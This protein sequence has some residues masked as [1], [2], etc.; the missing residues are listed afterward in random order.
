MGPLKGLRVIELQGIGPAPFCGMLLADLGAEVI[1]VARSSSSAHRASL[2]SDRGKLSIALNL[3]MREGAEVILKLCERC[4]V[5]IEGYRPGVTERLGIGPQPCMERN[6]RLVYGRMTGWGQTGPLS[7]AAGH[8]INYISLSGA[9]HA[10]GRK[11]ERPVPPLNLV[12]DFGGGAMFLAFGVMSAVFE[13][14]Q[15]GMG[16]VVDVSMVEGSAALM[17]MMFAMQAQGHWRD[18]RGT[19]LLDGAA[20]FYDAY[21]TA[22]GKYVSIGALEPEFY[23]V[24]VE[25][26]G[27]D[28]TN[29]PSHTESSE[30]PPLREK[31]TAI[32]KRRTRDEWCEILQGS[33]ACFAPVLST[34]EAPHHPHNRARGT[35]VEVAGV[36]QPAPVPRFSRTRPSVPATASPAGSDTG[37]V[38]SS[39]GYSEID[40]QALR[41]C[42]ALT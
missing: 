7:R 38:L 40:I 15:S 17:H 32:F 9:L 27:L 12:G 29:T 24:L 8:D 34:K 18:E 2:I 5:L 36:M 1:S 39:A 41:D 3:K 13:A 16:Q 25:L 37:A 11:G 31:L 35:F 19:N 30:W 33:D 26:T 4:D 22:D 20:P 23:R 28:A 21:E 6:P 42:G 10:I 14:R